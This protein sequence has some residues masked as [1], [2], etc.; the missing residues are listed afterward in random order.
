[1]IGQ[2]PLLASS[3][4]G[5]QMIVC[6]DGMNLTYT[7]RRHIHVRVP[8]TQAHAHAQTHPQTIWGHDCINYLRVGGCITNKPH[9]ADAT[10]KTRPI[11][12]VPC[13]ALHNSLSH[14]NLDIAWS[15]D[16]RVGQCWL[17]WQQLHSRNE[18]RT[19][20]TFLGNFGSQHRD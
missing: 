15:L 1:M 20:D 19:W 4:C 3:V 5:P 12:F 18:L 16:S 7:L 17:L 2:C 11:L 13:A 10:E 14:I 9:T 8:S 6:V